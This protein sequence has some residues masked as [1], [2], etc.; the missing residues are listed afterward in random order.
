MSKALGLVET[1]GLVGAIE[2]ADAMA[3]AANIK[4]IGRE[5]VAPA[6]ITIKCVGD[7]AA[8]KAAVD[9]GAAAAQRIGQLVSTHVIPQPDSQL[10]PFFLE[11][12]E[13]I[14]DSDIKS[15][16]DK[17]SRSPKSKKSTSQESEI[18]KTVQI[19]EEPISLNDQVTAVIEN[20]TSVSDLQTVDERKEV[21]DDSIIDNAIS[22]EIVD[23]SE[24][25][26]DEDN[27]ELVQRTVKNKRQVKPKKINK[28][29]IEIPTEP[30]SLFDKFEVDYNHLDKLKREA[31]AELSQE[32]E[33]EAPL[34]GLSQ[35]TYNYESDD[36][37]IVN[38]EVEEE[39][40]II[41]DV[42]EP[43]V[44]IISEKTD[45]SDSINIETSERDTLN[46]HQLRKLARQ[47]PN[48]PIQGRE[49]SKAN[50]TTLLDLFNKLV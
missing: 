50:R 43:E 23:H 25:S 7:V 4:I 42:I 34:D 10:E 21:V 31:L 22:D 3:K 15:I 37:S 24:I 5:K 45:K 38:S 32:V 47:T 30:S 39:N 19:V 46:V 26:L 2:A 29:E 8:V 12:D 35:D 28:K 14:A 40:V 44:I 9:A 6:L 36:E 1:R 20:E 48:F 41:R 27:S 13:S 18:N 16:L 11:I 17:P 49:I 33:D